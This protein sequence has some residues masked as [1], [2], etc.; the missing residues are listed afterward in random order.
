MIK[1]YKIIGISGGKRCGKDTISDY[2]VENYGFHK[3][4][5]ADPIRNVCK[6]IFDFSDEQLNGNLKDVVDEKWNVTPRKMFQTIGTELFQFDV[7]K[8]MDEGEFNIGRN[9]WV[10]KF[11]HWLEDL[12]KTHLWETKDLKILVSDIRMSHE[13]EMIR[14]LGGEVWNVTNNRINFE[15]THRTENEINE[16]TPDQIIENNGT[17]EEL[18]SKV[19]ILIDEDKIHKPGRL[20]LYVD[21]DGSALRLVN[22]KR[23]YRD[24]GIWEV[25]F[26]WKNGKLYSENVYD[27]AMD[28]LGGT[29]LIEITEEEWRKENGQYVDSSIKAT[30]KIEDDTKFY[31]DRYDD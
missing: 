18:Y 3:Y 9:I 10:L 21:L 11:K 17:L 25:G 29:E 15:D 12:E 28:Y 16:Y 14:E 27:E 2:L 13:I 23:Y 31:Y 22:G 30:T 20:P 24:A 4:T 1:N 8:Y 7:H 5:L 26:F 19:D 6:V